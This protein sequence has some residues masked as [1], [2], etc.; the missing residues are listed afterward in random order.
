VEKRVKKSY[1]I[2]LLLTLCLPVIA[3]EIE[4]EVQ[5]QE[6]RIEEENR[7]AVEAAPSHI[8][9]DFTSKVRAE[10]GGWINYRY[11]D[12]DNS[13]ND[14]A[15]AD[16]L[17]SLSL[18]DAR[19]WLRLTLKPGEDGQD[20]GGHAVYLRLKDRYAHRSGV[21]PGARYD[22]EGPLVDNAYVILDGDP[23]WLEAGRR[24]F[25]V[26]RGLAYSD[27][28]DGVQLNYRRP[29]FNVG[30]F[31]AKT[32]PHETNVD[33]S[34]P[35][36]DKRTERYFY[37]IG[38]G[39]TGIKDQSLYA[40]AVGQSDQSDEDS[41]DQ[42][43]TYNS[44]YLGIGSK[45]EFLSSWEYWIE[46]I[47][48]TG[49]SRTFGTDERR[50]VNAW[51]SDIEIAYRP[52]VATHP[53]LSAEYAFG[54]GDSDRASVTDTQSG[55]VTGQDRNFLYFGYAPTGFALA[56]RL[57]NLQMFRAGVEA[58]PFERLEAFRRLSC[59]VNYY[60]FLKH[61]S[62]GGV[63]DLDATADSIDIGHEVDL[64]ADWRILS[65][66]KVSLEYG[67]FMP[68]DA[69]ADPLDAAE[70]FFSLS[71]THTF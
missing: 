65:D 58:F 71:L 66:L 27:I 1:L 19:Y 31:T 28:H 56:P 69:Y 39:Y 16:A 29:G 37:G 26:G 59:G 34:I 32:L 33:L 22:N 35:G 9:K 13:D 44:Q 45:G 42:N 50:E 38:T 63:S 25:N 36:F 11:N 3:Q 30:V 67:H 49:A 7:A 21:A 47:K 70:D 12:F 20:P 40:F 24:Y 17:D 15:T 54:S 41:R 48:Q 18:I 8:W 5:E 55:N 10:Y 68:G 51:A 60:R 46:L 23:Y 14:K 43:Y 4:P 62:T 57:S 52:R 6:R 2:A 64:Y 61:R 53:R